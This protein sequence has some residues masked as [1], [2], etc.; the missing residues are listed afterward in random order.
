[1]CTSPWHQR[2]RSAEHSTPCF[3][4]GSKSPEQM[5]RGSDRYVG[6]HHSFRIPYTIRQIHHIHYTPHHTS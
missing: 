1:M 4:G 5:G 3:G 2:A 6:H